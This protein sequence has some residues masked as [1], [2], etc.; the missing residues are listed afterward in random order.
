MKFLLGTMAH[1]THVQQIAAALHEVDALGVY[2]SGGIDHWQRKSA[3]A[4]R[5]LIG[6]GIPAVNTI[7]ARRRITV[8]PNTFVRSDWTWELP[9]SVASWLQLDP[10]FTDW[11]WEKSEYHH[12]RKCA[13]LLQ[14]SRCNSFLGVEHGS[15]AALSVARALNK[16]SVLTF[17]SP[18]HAFRKRWVDAEYQRVPE[19]MTKS[20]KRISRLATRR[21]LRQDHET[22]IADIVLANSRLTARTLEE[23]GISSDKIITVPLGAPPTIPDSAIPSSSAGPMTF[24]YAG[25]VSVRKGAHI[26]LQAWNLLVPRRRAELHF[27]GSQQLPRRYWSDCPSNVVFHGSVPPDHLASGFDGAAALV[28]PTLCDGFGLVVTEALARGLPVVTTSNA[29]AVDVLPPEFSALIVPPGDVDALANS[30]EWCLSNPDQ[31]H[32]LR[33]SALTA[34]RNWTWRHFR[35]T[36]RDKLATAL[37]ID[38][39]VPTALHD[40]T[41]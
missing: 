17:L 7:L 34:A 3:R 41:S 39:K 9:R 30:L 19:L 10:R 8:V 25:P 21:D 12:D 14:G 13:R 4:L 32:A 28:F 33:H 22:K 20:Y 2:Y 18:H 15:L 5:G 6:R 35:T 40:R 38:F 16:K 11:I 24:V 26:L 31:L 1:N 29:G 37:N 27:Y 36:L 23:A